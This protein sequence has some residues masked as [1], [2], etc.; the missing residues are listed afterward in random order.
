MES[1]EQGYQPLP[2]FPGVNH[3]RPKGGTSGLAIAGFVLSIVGVLVI[4]AVLC[5]VALNRVKTYNEKGRGLAIAGLVVS[6]LWIVVG[7]PLIAYAANRDADRDASGQVTAAADVRSAK[8]R[9]GD[10]VARME[11][12][13]FRDVKV[14]P[15]T[16]PNGGRVFATFDLVVDTYP[17]VTSVQRTAEQGCMERWENSGE[18]AATPS[19]LWFL[20]PTGDSWRRG[21]QRITCLITP[22]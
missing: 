10:C 15:C 19:D 11:E 5:L 4:S 12:G 17:G 9:V 1:T 16:Q 13:V 8:L 21:D 6:G 7:L 22:S 3:E 18:E 20:Y 2:K 14:Q